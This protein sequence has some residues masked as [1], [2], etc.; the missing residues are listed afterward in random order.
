MNAVNRLPE[1]A[2]LALSS[3]GRRLQVVRFWVE[4]LSGGRRR[5][6]PAFSLRGTWPHHSCLLLVYYLVL[7]SLGA[8]RDR[9]EGG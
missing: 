4:V 9:P 8:G 2:L 1:E 6:T 5:F 3:R 7:M